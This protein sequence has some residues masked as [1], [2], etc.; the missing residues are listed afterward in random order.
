MVHGEKILDKNNYEEYYKQAKKDIVELKE[1]YPFTKIFLPPTMKLQP[2]QLDIIAA[3]KDLINI[4]HTS[5]ENYKGKYSRRLKVI[6]PFDYQKNG[7][8]VY[9]ASWVD[10]NKIPQK[11][12]HFNDMSDDEYLLCLGVPQSFTCMQNVIL[13]NIRTAENM[14]IAYELFMRGETKKIELIAYS[15]GKEGEYE[16]KKRKRKYK[17]K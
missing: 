6:V 17:S 8:K 11:D 4:S 16:Y 3:N 13:E 12:L 5:E 10:L 15:H 14:L 9:G 1:Q 2:F 7:C